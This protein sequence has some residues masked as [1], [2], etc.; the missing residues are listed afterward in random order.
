MKF[1]KLLFLFALTIATVSCSKNDDDNGPEPYTLSSTN[2]VDTYKLK[3]LEVKEVETITFSNGSTSES[4]AVTVGSVFQ[5]VNYLFNSNNTFTASGLF[6][7][8][9]T[10][11][12]ANGTVIIGDPVIVSL[13]ESGTYSLN[14]ANSKLTLT[15][16]EGEASSYEIQDYTE[17]GMTLYSEKTTISNNS[18]TTTTVEYRFSR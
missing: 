1:T 5:N 18:S 8:V 16:D 11:T 3:F 10:I 2:F 4:S 12:E 17:T 14:T 15:D 7:I 13:D 9:T 6:N